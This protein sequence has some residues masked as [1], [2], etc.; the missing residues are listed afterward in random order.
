LKT[1]LRSTLLALSLFVFV[2]NVY[3]ADLYWVG[4][5]GNWT[6]VQHWS[7]T[8]GGQG[9]ANVPGKT[10]DVHFDQN[11]FSS[12][13]QLVGVD[14]VVQCRSLDFSGLNNN[15]IFYGI[16]SAQIKIFGSFAITPLVDN[17]FAGEITFMGS[18]NS[19]IQTSEVDFPGNIRFAG[20]GTWTLQDNFYT[21]TTSEVILEKGTLNTNDKYIMAGVV[22][23]EG[24]ATKALNLGN[25]FIVIHKGW[26]FSN[27]RNLAFDAGTSKIV[28]RHVVDPVD[29]K[30][31]GLTYFDFSHRMQRGVV[32]CGTAP[33]DFTAEVV[34]TSDYNGTQISCCGASDGSICVNTTGGSGNF[35]YAWTFPPNPTTMCVTG[36]PAGSYGVIITDNVSGEACYDENTLQAP[37]CVGTFNF[38]FTNPTCNNTC[39]GSSTSIPIGGNGG[40][41][42]LWTPS[43]ETTIN[44]S[45]LCIGPNTL[46]I[47]DQNGCIFDTT[48]TITTPNP[49]FPNLTV[50][51]AQCFGDCDGYAVA[52]PSGGNGPAWSYVWSPAPGGGQGT[53]SAFALCGP[54][55][56]SGGTYSVT[57]TDALG[58][59]GDTTF[60]IT[61][62]VQMNVALNSLV[63]LT[64]NGV[65]TGSLNAVASNGTS[66]YT[67]Q[68]FDCNT[69]NPVPGQ[70]N[71]TANGLCAGDYYVE[72]TDNNGCTEVSICATVTEPPPLDVTG[73]VTD[74][75]CFGDC[76]GTGTTSATGGT[77]PYTFNWV[78]CNTSSSVGAGTNVNTL[79]AGDYEVIVTDD[80]GCMDTTAACLTV[81]EPIELT[82][83]IT[84]T[85]ILCFG[86]CTGDVTITIAGGVTPYTVEWFS[87]PPDAIILGETGLT[88]SN[89]C[90]GDYF[91]VVTD[92]N[93]CTDTT[94]TE[95]IVEPPVLDATNAI[96]QISC[97]GVCDGS[98]TSTVTGGVTPY[99]YQWFQGCPPGV[100]MGGETN[101][102]LN[103]LCAGGYYLVV[104]DGNGCTFQTGC[105]NITEPLAV[106]VQVTAFTNATCGGACDGDITV[107]VTGGTTPYTYNWFDVI[108]P[109]PVPGNGPTATGLCAGTYYVEVTDASGCTFTSPTQ[110]I[111]EAVVVTPTV[112]PV[113]ASCF[114]FC[115]GSASVTVTGGQSPYTYLWEDN[116]GNTISTSPTALGLCGP[117]AACG[118]T[119]TITITD[120]N[121]CSSPPTQ[122]NI[123]ESGALLATTDS[124]DVACFGDCDGTATVIPVGGTSPYTYVWS[125]APGGGQG[126]PTA[127]GLCAGT[128]DVSITDD[129]GCI[130]DTSIVVNEP[131]PFDIVSSQIDVLCFGDCDGEAS[132]T[133]NSGGTLPY[134]YT[135]T[136]APGGGQGT[137]TATGLCAGVWQVLI[138][139]ANN[140]D[141]T[142]TFTIVEPQGLAASIAIISNNSCNGDCAGSA[143]ATVAGGSLP[144]TY[145]WTPVPPGGQGT[146]TAT[147]LC[148]GVWQVLVEDA[149]GCDTTMSVTITEP[150]PYDITSSQTDVVCPG[151][152]DGTATATVNSGGT[153]PYTYLWDDPLAQTTPTAVGLCAGTY[154]VTVS[155]AFSCDSVLTF[156]ITAPPFW[157]VTP[158]QT[159]VLCNG[160]CDGTA[161]G[162]VNSGGTG[163]Y[164]Y[165]WVPAPGAGQGT[166]NASSMCPGSYDLTITDANNCDTILTFVITE[167]QALTASATVTQAT[168]GLIPC[169]G[170]ATLTVSGGQTPYIYNWTPAP[171]AGQGTPNASQMCAGIYQVDVTDAGGCTAQFTVVMS[172]NPS[173]ILTMDSTNVTCSG[174][175]DGSVTVTYTCSDP[176]CQLETWYNA[177]TLA[178]VGTG[179]TVNNLCAGTYIVEVINASGCVTLD[180]VQVAPGTQVFPNETVT[181][182]L[183]AGDCTGD[184]LVAPT[185]GL[186]PYTYNW[187][188]VP[189]GGQGTPNANGLCAGNWSVTITD[190][191]GCDTTLTVTLTD[192]PAMDVS[193][194]VSTDINC[195][196]D[197]DGT[198]T[199]F[200]TGGVPGFTYEW[201]D[202][203]TGLPI[204]QTGQ[205]ATNL[206]PGDYYCAV[207]DATGCTLNTIC[208][209]II[210]P[211][212]LGGTI[213]ITDNICFGDCDGSMIVTVTGGV[214]PFT[215]QWLNGIGN[216]I[217]GETA[218]NIQNLCDGAIRSVVVTD[219]NGCTTT[220]GTETISGPAQFVYTT[221]FTD[222][223][224][225]G[226][227]DG[228]ATITV[229]AGGVPPYTYL[230]DD[231]GAQTTPTATAL[232]PGTYTATVFDAAGCDTTETFIISEPLEVFANVSITT[233]VCNG[234]CNA[235][236]AAIPF[237]G[238]GSP[239][240]FLWGPGGETSSVIT[241]LC[242]G[243]YDLTVTDG[244]GCFKDTTIILTDPPAMTLISNVNDATCNQ[245]PCDGSASVIPGGGGGSPYTFSWSPAPLTGQGT[246]NVT[247]L[248]A[249]IYT[250]DITDNLGCTVQ[251]TVPVNN[252]GA[253][254]ITTDSTNV[255]CFGDCDGTATV[256]NPC[257]DAPC[258]IEWFNAT[259][260]ANIGQPNV[261]TAVGLCADD[262]YVQVTNASGCI[263]IDPVTILEPTAIDAN[264]VI[265]QVTCNGDTDGSILVVPT[266]GPS[267]TYTYNWVPAPGGG[268]G[269]ANATGLGAGSWSVTIT[270]GVCDSTYTFTITDPTQ[271]NVTAA[272]TD[273]NCAAQCDGT[274]SVTPTGGV[275]PYTYQWLDAGLTPIPG[276]TGS[277]I[278]NLCAG[279]YYVEIT[280]A[281]GCVIV[282]QNPITI[283]EPTALAVSIAANDVLCAGDCTGDATVTINGGTSPFITNWYSSPSNTLI[284]QTGLT[285]VG[286]CAGDYYAIVT[287]ANNCAV[288]TNTVTISE[289]APLTATANS[290][291]A[292]CNGLC[293]G[294]GSVAPVGGT[295]PYTY[296]WFDN[297]QNVIGNSST[298]NSLCAGNY[299]VVVTDANG[300]TVGPLA[301]TISQPS[302]ITGVLTSN[303]ANCLQSDGS[304]SITAGG[305]TS[306]YTYQWFDGTMTLLVG[307]TNATINNIPAGT[308][309][310][311]VTDASGC[312]AL[313]SV[314]VSN[315][316]AP[317]ITIDNV[318]DVSCFGSCDGGIN[319]SIVGVNPPFTYIW[320]P[321]GIVSEDLAGACAG[322][323]QVQVTDAVGCISFETAT[324][325]EPTE[326]TGVMTV[327][328]GTC[329]LCD[330]QATITPSGGTSPYTFDWTN[331]QTSGTATG[332]CPGVYSVMVTDA[333][334]CTAVFDA[335][336]G[337]VG[338]PSI[339][340]LNITAVS[341]D[342]LCDGGADITPTGGTPPYTYFWPHSSETTS[343]VSSLCEGQYFVQVADSNGCMLVVVVDVPDVSPISDSI[344]ITPATCGLCDGA[345]SVF[346]S[347]GA[348]PY[349]YFW[350]HN[351]STNNSLSGMCEGFY[352]VEVTDNAG[353]LETF[354]VTINGA[355]APAIVLTGTDASCFGVCDGSITSSVVGGAS[356]YAYQWL[357]DTGTPLVPAET[358]PDL[359]NACAGTY[360]LE[361]TDAAGCMA[362][363]TVTIDEPTGFNFSLPN[364]VDASCAVACNGSA[365]VLPTGGV[366]PYVYNW[367]PT[368][369]T[370]QTATGLCS[371]IHIVSVTDANGCSGGQTM[372]INDSLNM[373]AA[374]S[375]TDATCGLCDGIAAVTPSGGTGPYTYLWADGSTGSSNTGLCAGVH[376]VEITDVNGCS[377]IID[378][379][380][381]NVGGPTGENIVQTDVSCFGGNDG[382]VTVTPVGGTP[383][384]TYNWIPAGQTTNSLSNMTAG[385]YSL[386]MMDANG[387]IR[388]VQVV[389]NEPDEI[390]AN[391]A[392]TN[393]NCGVCNGAVVLQTS[394]G[395]GPYTYVWAPAPGSGQ[396]TS[397]VSGLCAGMYT[398]TIT[399]ASGCS[400][401]ANIPVSSTNGADLAMTYTPVV[402]N[403]ACDGTADVTATGGSGNYT[404]L[405]TPGGQTT[406]NVTALCAGSY[407]VEVTDAT[408]GCV[409]FASITVDEPDSTYFSFPNIVNATCGGTCD[410]E[411]TVIMTGG[412]LPYSYTWTSGGTTD[413]ETALCAGTWQVTVTDA[414][415]CVDTL[416]ITITEPPIIVITVDQVTDATCINTND[417]S[418]DVTVTGGTPPYAY[419]WTSI[420]AGFTSTNEDINSLFPMNYV[421][422][423]TDSNGCVMT[424][425]IPVD[426]L[427]ILIADAG[428][429][430]SICLGDSVLLIGTWIG[431][432]GTTGEWQ[433]SLGNT[434]STNDSIY[435][436][437]G[438]TSDYIF[439]VQDANCQHEDTVTVTINPLPF[440]DAGPDIDMFAGT[441][442]MIGGTPTGPAGSDYAW[443]PSTNLNDST[444]SNPSVSPPDTTSG[445]Y[446]VFVTDTNGCVG[447][448]SMFV[449]VLP[450][451]TFPNGFSPNGDGLNDVWEID[452]ITQFEESVVEVYNRWG[453]LLFRSVGYDVPWDGTYNG[454]P[455]PVGT[456][457]YVIDLNHELHPEAYTGPL[458]IL[459]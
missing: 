218:D 340:T 144:Y 57:V 176:P 309:N 146:P 213:A 246:A 30:M 329:G 207:T 78:T 124:T 35:S 258:T 14:N 255:T 103:G 72:V 49:I 259:T 233:N 74:V 149:N 114:G 417:G 281:N 432:P 116:C 89:R 148:A 438:N 381:G 183:C 311:E 301:I 174:D 335:N 304:A 313:F 106:D 310:V 220:I 277:T 210:E 370:T 415:S 93:G 247:G 386:E 442:E 192:P 3:S 270:D 156:I 41:T 256:N 28:V 1:I 288:Q 119:Y 456:Y 344:V 51:D 77:T 343:A 201:F 153:P 428:P 38:Q 436:T 139:D 455:V 275:P 194:I 53:D 189:G 159:D 25:S 399:D 414:S 58:C 61:E 178:T 60:Q 120:D 357:D 161:S 226:D 250:V 278:S 4:G 407:M 132:V 390:L 118:G 5:A 205:Q 391:P 37:T 75:L 10:D 242:A 238:T 348:P 244:N 204:G 443:I 126:T 32:N 82:T 15:M 123:N 314:T 372:I 165:N 24:S 419:D 440:A 297:L 291:D 377:T 285:A 9:G 305:G 409:S 295:T 95:T 457:Y 458:T 268:Q 171:G 122:F 219:A 316:N 333:N 342:G 317:V 62:P 150:N 158:A 214:S 7:T 181:D 70:N 361:V 319:I 202:C 73:A 8:S 129:A 136:P 20:S 135:W 188:P 315:I 369:Q 274:A 302:A 145:T 109:T 367:S 423:V 34:V 331:T 179:T 363:A 16:S 193:N 117:S 222:V 449:N 380:V 200:P 388:V 452:F 253:E 50:S 411:A 102:V 420:P 387:C 198:A 354:I 130:L 206:A 264:E 230:W 212:A 328:D 196:G 401:V 312:T 261:T 405:W 160:D 182:P 211:V 239:Y 382:S 235:T 217:A 94:T 437:P 108:G 191:A 65:C 325:G 267:G 240:T 266:G 71:Q 66:P 413:N 128:W 431:S 444:L 395:V 398:V 184:I 364:I 46:E 403:G 323:Y 98:L 339:G 87:T 322:T 64:C 45:L 347:G 232:C 186:S 251:F 245:V 96:G 271:I 142:V 273:A 300:C 435:V 84:H 453:E 99:A 353:C 197:D 54:S 85:D 346:N 287:D 190:Q 86:D 56:P 69:N 280:D 286:L 229:T 143:Q 81:N 121:G 298:I 448:D 269:T 195:N 362:F 296:E 352:T 131:P 373:T 154:T 228:T 225:F 243:T 351:G 231:P 406:S 170:A 433:D 248:C 203:T 208:I 76:N 221:A 67:Y 17:Q 27:N 336:V 2:I 90:A 326:I 257:L 59:T 173:E 276:E 42:F 454:K 111:T 52:N 155:D 115:D 290:T 44:A 68:W 112:T 446:T 400:S 262:Y 279:D 389:I 445:W 252:I 26:D 402:C 383:P 33:N 375:I 306:P 307:E 416:S 324:I 392:I 293:D 371:G 412:M 337:D 427:F 249:G 459:R 79:C 360:T 113:D 338:G 23:T 216:P 397:S 426:T 378:V 88:I 134:T 394:G 91:A 157:D 299:T 283:T 356:P 19:T 393:A 152:C 447:V 434:I 318:I 151:D 29:V 175:C 55:G 177:I 180:S 425:T 147:G 350:P 368:T 236:L 327:V 355:T 12:N 223:S 11:S 418:I 141:S 365:T 332:L 349:T 168:C 234:D 320:N 376:P 6:D 83:T 187:V 341:C 379:T 92:A 80:N 169:D 254:I 40:Y 22:N 127:T 265:T 451:I 18:G 385:T 209:T 224:C 100:L 384:Y 429:D 48:I 366:L 289:P 104:T 308:Y 21:S 359:L 185:G 294:T 101:P 430:T 97:N 125:P 107:T 374:T 272:F 164:T 31:G 163:P 172:N 227:C 396:G 166:P 133:V 241:N 199:V 284:G 260:G 63:H 410:G 47:T 39:D 421:L 358:N 424:D 422:A 441:T 138:E 43:G 404:Y 215:Y 330:G 439:F 13:D 303:D 334:G 36:L 162:T 345:V 237:G 321:G 263:T 105:A 292:S 110:L 282:T 137:P 408:T 140:C 167:P 450:E